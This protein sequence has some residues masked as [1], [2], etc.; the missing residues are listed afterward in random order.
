M[1]KSAITIIITI[2]RSLHT[3]AKKKCNVAN[4]SMSGWICNN[5]I[6]EETF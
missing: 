2:S 1:L 4:S 5:K 6:K 3:L